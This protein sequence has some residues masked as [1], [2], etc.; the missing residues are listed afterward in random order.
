[1]YEID[2]DT[3][4]T[5]HRKSIN[6]TSLLQSMMLTLQSCFCWIRKLIFHFQLL[7]IPCITVKHYNVI[8]WVKT[9]SY[10]SELIT[11]KCQTLCIWK[12]GE[13]IPVVWEGHL[14]DEHT[15]THTHT[16]SSLLTGSNLSERSRDG[17]TN[18]IFAVH[19]QSLMCVNEWKQRGY[20]QLR[21]YWECLLALARACALSACRACYCGSRGPVSGLGWIRLCS[22]WTPW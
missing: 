10:W 5:H 17:G 1:M 4:K 7:K 22:R 19:S 15:H 2:T 18:L 6:Q 21:V 13:E 11:L 3:V 12:G 9:A 8:V 20:F 16:H 14:T